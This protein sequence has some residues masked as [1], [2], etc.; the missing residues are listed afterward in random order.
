MLS[1]TKKAYTELI[2]QDLEYLNARC[3]PL[4]S[5]RD[6]IALIICKSI[7]WL[8]PDKPLFSETKAVEAF[9]KACPLTPSKSN[10][11]GIVECGQC[12]ASKNFINALKQ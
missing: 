10:F 2:A 9:I 12:D 6:Y 11:C 3:S 5:E 8:Y 4:D 7:D 1:I